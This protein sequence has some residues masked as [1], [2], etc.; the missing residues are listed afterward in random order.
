MRDLRL[1]LRILSTV[2]ASALLLAAP[3]FA[4]EGSDVPA[5]S[6]AGATFRWVN[7]AIVFAGLLY[8]I[9]KWGAPGFRRHAEDISQK[10][11]EGTRAREAAEAQRAEIR[12]KLEG[13]EAEVQK[14][15]VDAKR[16]AEA[17]AQRLRDLSKIE[18]QKIEANA[19]AEISAAIRAGQLRLKSLTARNAIAQAEELLRKE[20]SEAADS[21]LVRTFVKDLEGSVN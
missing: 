6:P 3:A 16:E 2:T 17:E 5:D 15:R 18:A 1:A 19:Q 21:N 12:A 9:L 11:A 4:Q 14:M 20:I 13:L 10:I 7:F 8:V